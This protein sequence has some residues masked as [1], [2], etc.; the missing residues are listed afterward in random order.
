MKLS[1]RIYK[2]MN[3]RGKGAEACIKQ[4]RKAIK[5][6]LNPKEHNATLLLTSSVTDFRSVVHRERSR[7]G[8]RIS[9]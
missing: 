6:I 1:V 8:S 2:I 4:V 9:L 7:T 5:M 3:I